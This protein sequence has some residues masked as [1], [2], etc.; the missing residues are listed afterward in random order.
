MDRFEQAGKSFEALCRTMAT[1]RAPD[2][3][4]WDREQTFE[5]LKTY[6]LEETY[7]T[8]DAIETGTPDDHC[9]ELGDL[10][11]QVVLEM[12]ET[13]NRLMCKMARVFRLLF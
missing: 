10:I 11:L 8:L 9:E 13:D 6:L 3:C 12:Q 5:S 7:E 2:G 4:P 1:L